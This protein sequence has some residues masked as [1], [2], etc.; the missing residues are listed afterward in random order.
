MG[1]FNARYSNQP[2]KDEAAV[3]FRAR[4]RLGSVR[5]SIKRND[6]LAAIIPNEALNESN[7]DIA[8]V[9]NP[10]VT[11]QT[12]QTMLKIASNNFLNFRRS[13]EQWSQH[14]MHSKTIKPSHS[15]NLPQP[16][17]LKGASSITSPSRL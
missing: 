6:S 13:Q 8:P 12:Q 17:P 10:K 16:K 2:F 4:D 1:S 15:K 9:Y 3:S 7:I 5:N 14:Q 11:E